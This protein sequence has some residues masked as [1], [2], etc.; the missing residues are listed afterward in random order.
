MLIIMT[1]HTQVRLEF[2]NN[3]A[4]YISVPRT[5]Y[6][7]I[8]QPLGHSIYLQ[9]ASILTMKRHDVFRT[10]IRPNC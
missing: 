4:Q 3:I 2:I 9:Q 1:M 5:F 7:V 6:A 10:A 8:Y